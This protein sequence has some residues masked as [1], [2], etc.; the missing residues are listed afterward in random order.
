MLL[1]KAKPSY[2]YQNSVQCFITSP[3]LVPS[4]CVLQH[5]QDVFAK[6][7][8]PSYLKNYRPANHWL[9][10]FIS[11]FLSSFLFFSK[12]M[13][14]F[15]VNLFS[16]IYFRCDSMMILSPYFFVIIIVVS[17]AEIFNNFVIHYKIF[18]CR[19]P[20]QMQKNFNVKIL[21]SLVLK[22]LNFVYQ[23]S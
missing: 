6:L 14:I 22:F 13:S 3:V 16:R 17:R 1:G 15:L 19:R 21:F 20:P 8:L 23:K 7:V 18:R 10:D 4:S 12:L 9:S 2:V 5:T 11:H